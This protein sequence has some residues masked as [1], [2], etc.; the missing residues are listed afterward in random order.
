MPKPKLPRVP[1]NEAG[2]YT[3]WVDACM[4]G[5]GA[6]PLSS[7]FDYAGPLTEAVLMG[8]LAIRS[9]SLRKMNADGQG[10]TY[11]GRKKLLWDA[12]IMKITNFD[13]ANAFVKNEYRNGWSLN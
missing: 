12:K 9:Y 13:D 10:Y 2:H 8:N 1:G 5:F 7:E 3:Q 4:K 11:P 6:M